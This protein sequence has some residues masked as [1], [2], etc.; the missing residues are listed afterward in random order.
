MNSTINT[1]QCSK[2]RIWEVFLTSK[3]CTDHDGKS[4]THTK[5][6]H[7]ATFQC[8]TFSCCSRVTLASLLRVSAL[9]WVRAFSKLHVGYFVFCCQFHQFC[10]MDL[11]ERPPCFPFTAFWVCGPETFLLPRPKESSYR[12]SSVSRLN[13]MSHSL[14]KERR[15][16]E[17][18]KKCSRRH[19]LKIQ[20]GHV[21][22]DML[23][24]DTL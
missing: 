4:A 16:K 19:L 7:R 9:R 8:R 17:G 22:R 3:T 13:I 15:K 10:L 21:M 18:R 14:R 2:G 23:V 12:W 20:S 1:K 11:T 5:H 6:I 24:R